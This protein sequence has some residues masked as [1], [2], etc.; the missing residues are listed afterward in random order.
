MGKLRV[1]IVDDV[2]S[3]RQSLHA[4]LSLAGDLEV[5]GEATNG[6]EGVQM[7][8]RLGPDV[9]LMDLQMPL[10][11]GWAAAREITRRGLPCAVV[12]LTIHDDPVSRAKAQS[13]G[14]KAFLRKGGSLQEISAALRACRP[15]GA[16]HETGR[17]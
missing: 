7:A 1:L 12:A 2:P 17:C 9:V 6:L 16:G 11:D 13:A 14:I 4:L 3:V 10:L 8:A 15:S 5:V